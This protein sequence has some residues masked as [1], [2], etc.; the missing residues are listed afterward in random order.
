[1]SFHLHEN[2]ITSVKFQTRL[3]TLKNLH[4]FTNNFRVFLE[5]KDHS[6]HHFRALLTFPGGPLKASKLHHRLVSMPDEVEKI[7]AN[8]RQQ[9]SGNDIMPYD[10]AHCCPFSISTT[11]FNIQ[12]Q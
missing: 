8:R 1:M 2:F 3:R 5:A 11:N 4:S 7:V 12:M 6:Y 10:N 9:E